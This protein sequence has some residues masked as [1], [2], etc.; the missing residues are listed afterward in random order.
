M[1]SKF[2]I[3]LKKVSSL[4]RMC[5]VNGVRLVSSNSN[6]SHTKTECTDWVTNRRQMLVFFRWLQNEIKQFSQNRQLTFHQL[7][8]NDLW[9]DIAQ[10]SE[11]YF[12]C[13]FVLLYL[14]LHVY[15][16]QSIE[17]SCLPVS[18]YLLPPCPLHTWFAMIWLILIFILIGREYFHPRYC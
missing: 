4:S 17:Y 2:M 13:L 6:S 8:I 3:N 10:D 15:P 16:L 18:L 5:T 1:Q 11:P 12:V 9:L 7:K 14:L